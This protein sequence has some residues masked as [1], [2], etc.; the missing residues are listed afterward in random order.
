[1]WKIYSFKIAANTIECNRKA[2]QAIRVA[3][4]TMQTKSTICH[5]ITKMLSRDHIY[6]LF[7]CSI[8]RQRHKIQPIQLNE[9]QL[10]ENSCFETYKCHSQS[11]LKRIDIE[12][13]VVDGFAVVVASFVYSPFK[14]CTG[15]DIAFSPFHSFIKLSIR[16]CFVV[17]AL[18]Q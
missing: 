13:P 15:V 1:M 18:F 14:M 12:L 4:S 10:Y 9:K 8:K 5:D 2:T 3:P 17:V 11:Q 16:N 6:S 7:F